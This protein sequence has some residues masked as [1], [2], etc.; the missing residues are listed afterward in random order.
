M[1]WSRLWE[2]SSG[3]AR[4]T[5]LLYAHLTE[6]ARAEVEVVS[7]AEVVYRP[8]EQ[9]HHRDPATI[10][11]AYRT[12]M[13]AATSA[14]TWPSCT[15]LCASIGFPAMSPMAKILGTLVRI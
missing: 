15:A 11:E 9:T 6:R 14:A 8:P 3:H 2:L 12:A 7:V 5:R 10:E 13:E 4:G 1:A